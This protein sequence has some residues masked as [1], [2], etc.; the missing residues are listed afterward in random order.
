MNYENFMNIVRSRRSIRSHKPDPINDEIIKQV[1]EAGKW[2]PSGNN[3]QPLEIV[4]VKDKSIIEQMENIIA[5]AYEPKLTQHFGAPVMLVVL[6]DPRFCEA[7]PKGFLREEIL[8]SSLAAVIENMLLAS[9]A[10]GLGG[11]AWKTV[12]SSAAVK[13]KDLLGI[14]Q[15]YVL[16]ALIPLGYP[17]EDVEAPPKRDIVVHEN[18]YNIGK[19]K[20]EEEVKEIINKYSVVKHLNKLR[21]L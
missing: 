8:H 3:T 20:N 16:K 6:G 4:V 15:L 12:P 14:P 9:T 21:A 2:A 19:L 5:Q 17:K 11:G 18:R 7:Y 1:I 10:L 13:I